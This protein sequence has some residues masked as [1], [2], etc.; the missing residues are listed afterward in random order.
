M[1]CREKAQDIILQLEGE[2]DLMETGAEYPF[3]WDTKLY[4]N[5]TR[6]EIPVQEQP[7]PEEIRDLEE[8]VNCWNQKQQIGYLG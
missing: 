8:L 2:I 7:S 4:T 1:H 6:Y 3:D 5:L